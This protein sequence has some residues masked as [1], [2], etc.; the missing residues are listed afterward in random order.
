MSALLVPST[1]EITR[2]LILKTL[3]L[4]AE[5]VT[6]AVALVPTACTAVLP[7]IVVTFTIL[8]ADITF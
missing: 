1:F 8:G 3:L 5:L 2:L 6:I 7:I 4:A